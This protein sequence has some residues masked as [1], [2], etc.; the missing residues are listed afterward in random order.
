MIFTLFDD[1][2]NIRLLSNSTFI[3][4]SNIYNFVEKYETLQLFNNGNKFLIIK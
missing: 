3:Q 1:L 4:D 2:Y